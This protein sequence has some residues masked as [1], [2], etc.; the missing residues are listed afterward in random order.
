MSPAVSPHHNRSPLSFP[1]EE[2]EDASEPT[3]RDRSHLENTLKLNEDKPADDFSG[4]GTHVDIQGHTKA[5][6]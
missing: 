2:V 3:K 1:P 4:E 5:H 6:S